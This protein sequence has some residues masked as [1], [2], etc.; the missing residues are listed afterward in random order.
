[1]MCLLISFL[2]Q[3][4]VKMSLVC[5]QQGWDRSSPEQHTNAQRTKQ[6]IPWLFTIT[7]LL[8]CHFRAQSIEKMKE[9]IFFFFLFFY[10]MFLL[11]PRNVIIYT[12][13]VLF[14]TL[15]SFAIQHFGFFFLLHFDSTFFFMS[16]KSS[17]FIW[18][19]TLISLFSVF[20]SKRKKTRFIFTAENFKL[21]VCVC[22]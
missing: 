21:S 13:F 12:H 5:F 4:I 11:Y 15:S 18:M 8:L 3:C 6:K 1:M 10:A 16:T 19:I 22:V 9:T 20:L 14:Y 17:S 7:N 2:A